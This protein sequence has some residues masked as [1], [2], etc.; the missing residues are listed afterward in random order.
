VLP[1]LFGSVFLTTS[2]LR[3]GVGTYGSVNARLFVGIAKTA[4]VKTI[5]EWLSNILT[6]D[7]DHELP[8]I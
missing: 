2:R 1:S 7:I 8:F 3:F 5:L 4:E 6:T